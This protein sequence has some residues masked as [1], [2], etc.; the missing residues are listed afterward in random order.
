[1]S[2]GTEFGGFSLKEYMANISLPPD[3]PEDFFS[4]IPLQRLHINKLLDKG[5]VTS[6]CLSFDRSRLWVT[7]RAHSEEAAV[8]IIA[9]FPLF[10]WMEVEI[11]QLMFRNTVATAMPSVSMN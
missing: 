5:V 11:E 8:E 6:Y 10:R 3:P 4:L 7:L 2:Q 1:M 9:A